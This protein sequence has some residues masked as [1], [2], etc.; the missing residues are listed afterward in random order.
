MGADTPMP[1]PRV[2]CPVA[3][4]LGENE[5]GDHVYMGCERPAGH[6]G[7]HE[8]EDEMPVVIGWGSGY[9]ATVQ[10]RWPDPA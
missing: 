5:E 1:A 8:A 4:D 6:A 9:T 2:P 10:V 7:H 3:L